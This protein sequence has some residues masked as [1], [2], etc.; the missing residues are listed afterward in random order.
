MTG[1]S[2]GGSRSA[3]TTHV[4]AVIEKQYV[5]ILASRARD[6]EATL[7]EEPYHDRV[8]RLMERLGRAWKPAP[9]PQRIKRGRER[10]CFVNAARLVLR[11]PE[12]SYVEGWADFGE[13]AWCV[14]AAGEVL[15]P[16]WPKDRTL[17]EVYFGVAFRTQW[18]R[19]VLTVCGGKKI[20]LA[21][22]P[23]SVIFNFV[24]GTASLAA[25]PGE[26]LDLRWYQLSGPSPTPR[27]GG[28][29]GTTR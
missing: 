8:R 27:K 4:R 26:M 14:N 23:V 12:L 1:T 3:A 10:L 18:I 21:D 16:T 13:H 6:P 29:H 11:H 25:N 28:S 15:D 2:K 9:L 22:V 5:R 24:A 20:A 19:K 7:P 17:P